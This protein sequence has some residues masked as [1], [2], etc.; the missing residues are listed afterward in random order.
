MLAAREYAAGDKLSSSSMPE[1]FAFPKSVRPYF[2]SASG[3]Y[4]RNAIIAGM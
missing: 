1:I 4:P 2:F 3:P